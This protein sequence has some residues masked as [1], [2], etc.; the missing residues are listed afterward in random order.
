MG[1]SDDDIEI[2]LDYGCEPDEIEDLLYDPALLN[3]VLYEL[4]SAYI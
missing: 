1:V 3:E 2:L 4:R